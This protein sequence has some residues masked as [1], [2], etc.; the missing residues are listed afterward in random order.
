LPMY[1]DPKW[2]TI[3]AGLLRE[4]ILNRG[5]A[6]I[7]MC[8]YGNEP[9]G[10]WT[11][12][13]PDFSDY[14]QGVQNLRTALNQPGDVG[15]QIKISGSSSYWPD[16]NLFQWVG[17]TASQMSAAL[18]GYDIHWYSSSDELASDYLQTSVESMRA[19]INSN[20]PDGS[21]KDF[22]ILEAGIVNPNGDYQPGV[23]EFCCGVAMADYA[24]Q[25]MRGG[26]SEIST[27]Y[28]DDAMYWKEWGFWNSRNSTNGGSAT[29]PWFYAWSMMSQL[30]PR[31]G[32]TDL[33]PVFRH[34]RLNCGGDEKVPWL[35]L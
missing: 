14:Q 20:D 2:A 25:A 23:T 4:L 13:C 12:G 35:Q 11:Y 28:L 29:R 19:T 18:G 33:H 7:S 32:T 3:I 9:N 27:W 30:F 5:Y 16:S 26:I 10:W 24:A 15:S 21:S 34:D 31:R 22:Y 8:N 17:Q 1:N 6:C